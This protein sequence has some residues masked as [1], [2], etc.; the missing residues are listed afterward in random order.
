MSLKIGH[1]GPGKSWKSPGFSF[2]GKRIGIL[3]SKLGAGGS[4][5]RHKGPKV[6]NQRAE[7]GSYGYGEC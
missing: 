7:S 5:A 3:S 1:G 4:V 2:V 6:E